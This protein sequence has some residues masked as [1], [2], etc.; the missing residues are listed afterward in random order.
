VCVCVCVCVC[1]VV[2]GMEEERGGT[3]KW[4]HTVREGADVGLVRPV[5]AVGFVLNSWGTPD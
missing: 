4:E 1:V 3:C 5:R 2:V